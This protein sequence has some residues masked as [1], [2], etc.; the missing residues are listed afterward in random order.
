MGLSENVKNQ[1][2]KNMEN[3]MNIA[4]LW[5][6]GSGLMLRSFDCC[7]HL[8]CRVRGFMVQGLW[9]MEKGM[10]WNVRLSRET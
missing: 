3:E 4:K 9:I 1:V 5:V 2:D 8:G 10:K 6:W 7:Q